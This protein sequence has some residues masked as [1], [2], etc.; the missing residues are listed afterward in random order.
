MDEKPDGRS[1]Y[2][3]IKRILQVG[4]YLESA[5]GKQKRTLRRMDN[6]FF[7]N[8]E[9]LYRRTPNLGFLQCVDASEA[10]RLLKKIHTGTYGPYINGF[11]LAKKILSDRYFWMAMERDSIRYMQKCHQCQVHKDF[12]WVPPYELNVMG[13]PY[14]FVSWV[15]DVI[16]PIETPASNGHHFILVAIDYFTKV[17]RNKNGANLNSD[18]MRDICERFK[19]A[20]RNSLAYRPQM[21]GAI[22]A[23][24]KNIKQILRKIVD[25]NRNVMRSYHMLY[26][27]ITEVGL[28]D[29]EW[30]RSR[31]K[32]LML[33]DEKRL[34]TGPYIVHQVLLGGVV[35]LAEMDGR[36]STKPIN[37]DDSKKYY[38]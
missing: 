2:Y 14:P 26:L 22:E 21:N 36:V 31:I 15:M 8:K 25:G 33:I 4:E 28:D 10:T 27:D 20:H 13:S 24:N 29:A 37:S 23:A 18:L 12:I 3:D 19:T 9:I 1:C 17:N 34:E 32:Q 38:I 5:T 35:I 7:L 6:H 30:I 16:G 11:M